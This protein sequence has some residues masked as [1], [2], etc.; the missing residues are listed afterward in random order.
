MEFDKSLIVI[1]AGIMAVFMGLLVW[2]VVRGQG[3]KVATGLEAMVGQVVNVKTALSPEGMV[4]AEGELWRAEIDSG[5]AQP[6]EEVV[7]QRVD[8]LKLYVTKKK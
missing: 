3:R 2:A 6:G 1:V 4:V 5:T 8:N 7:I